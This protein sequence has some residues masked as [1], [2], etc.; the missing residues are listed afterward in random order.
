MPQGVRLH[1]Y[2]ATIR[3]ELV[4]LPQD[5]I[6]G[7]LQTLQKIQIDA[8][9]FKEPPPLA[10][11]RI[12]LR[13][14]RTIRTNIRFLYCS[15]IHWYQIP[16]VERIEFISPSLLEDWNG[17]G[18]ASLM[19]FDQ[20]KELRCA[21]MDKELESLA[22]NL[23]DFKMVTR[24]ELEGESVDAMLLYFTLHYLTATLDITRL[25]FPSLL[26]LVI[27]NYNGNGSSVVQFLHARG[28]LQAGHENS[29]FS[30]PEVFLHECSAISLETRKLI[31]I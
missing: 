7:S 26:S 5:A 19:Q 1:E 27:T 23:I 3:D 29:V 14:L 15:F 12:T 8:G 28:E 2:S 11:E 17:S 18:A 4:R 21:S 6:P 30:T 9:S 31:H 22:E 25:I 16:K 20:I 24:L 10:H 13:N